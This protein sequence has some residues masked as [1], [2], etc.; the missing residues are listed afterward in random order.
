MAL[1]RAPQPVELATRSPRPRRRRRSRRGPAR[2]RSRPAAAMTASPA[3][4]SQVPRPCRIPPSVARARR[5]VVVDRHRV[6]VPGDH[7]PLRPPEVGARHHVVPVAQHLEVRRPAQRRLHGVR[8]RLLVATHRL[9]VDQAGGQ[10]AASRVRSRSSGGMATIQPAGHAEVRSG[11]ARAAPS[12]RGGRNGDARWEKWR[13]AEPPRFSQ[14]SQRLGCLGLGRVSQR[15]F[16]WGYGTVAFAGS[17]VELVDGCLQ[18]V[19]GDGGQVQALG[20]VFAE[21]PV[22][23]LVGPRCQ[24]E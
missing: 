12:R 15:G 11:P 22:D 7:H 4:M 9:D 18:F 8:D 6:E 20:E 23:V 14:P 10:V 21:Q 3:F 24:G 2:A 16:R 13:S 1:R 5:Q 17:V 19:V